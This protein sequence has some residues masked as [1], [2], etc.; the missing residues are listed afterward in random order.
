MIWRVE[1][2]HLRSEIFFTSTRNNRRVIF[3]KHQ[4]AMTQRFFR[5]GSQPRDIIFIVLLNK[6][7]SGSAIISY[8]CILAMFNHELHAVIVRVIFGA[9]R[10]EIKGIPMILWGLW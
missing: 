2:E 6:G 5:F 10:F 8:S 1:R 9:S 7:G 4:A 3:H